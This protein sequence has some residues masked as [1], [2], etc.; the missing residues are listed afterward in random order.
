MNRFLEESI[1]QIQRPKQVSEDVTGIPAP[2]QVLSL[3]AGTGQPASLQWA[4]FVPTWGSLPLGAL[5]ARTFLSV[6]PV[7]GLAAHTS[8]T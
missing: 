3:V 4:C 8:H 2:S 7:L 1:G 5:S 6:P